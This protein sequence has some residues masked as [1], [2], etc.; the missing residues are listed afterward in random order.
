MFRLVQTSTR[1][2]LFNKQRQQ[3]VASFSSSSTASTTPTVHDLLINLTIVDPSGA[4]KKIKGI[5]GKTLYEACEL[6][7]VQLG[8]ASYGGNWATK[9]SDTWEEP[10]FGEGACG[11]YDH[12]VLTGKGS[13]AVEMAPHPPEIDM[14]RDYWDGNELYEGS[15]LA[16]QVKINK[17]MDGMVVFVPDR[18]DDE[19]S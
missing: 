5:I 3:I 11:G 13:D 10:T 9:R 12:V 19:I 6:Q 1:R 16:S 8:L 4:R 15:R 17:E 18:I 14:L 2:F 7:G